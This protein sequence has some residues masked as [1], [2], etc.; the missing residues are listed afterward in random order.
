MISKEMY[1]TY[2]DL[3]KNWALI[4]DYNWQNWPSSGFPHQRI[5]NALNC[6]ESLDS[7]LTK[8]L[9]LL[10][11]ACENG[12]YSIPATSKFK[13]VIGFDIDSEAIA[14]AQ[15]T[16]NH[17]AAQGFDV[18]NLEFKVDDYWKYF[19]NPKYHNNESLKWVWHKPENI[20]NYRDLLDNS[21]FIHD[22]VDALL[23]CEFFNAVDNNGVK[24]LQPILKKLKLV[25]I[26]S[27]YKQNNQW[28][29]IKDEYS[30]FKGNFQNINN[31][32][33]TYSQEGIASVLEEANYSVSFYNKDDNN[34]LVIGINNDFNIT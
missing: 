20:N 12:L 14:K 17:Y 11:L 19:L 9:T 13:K 31:S 29:F 18:S 27:K 30:K 5:S 23:G 7:N 34:G 32:F 24:F 4:S 28:E 15:L 8:E 33:H 21:K 6:I 2:K 22:K 1:K 10:D 25:I 26:Q 3:E 16:K